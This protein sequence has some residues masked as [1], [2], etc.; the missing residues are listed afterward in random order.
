LQREPRL[1][2]IEIF[3]VIAE[4]RTMTDAAKRLHVT[5]P[6]LSR[7]LRAL[8]ENLNCELFDRIGRQLVLTAAG[9][10]MADE[11]RRLRAEI[12][13]AQTRIRRLLERQYFNLRIGAIDSILAMAMPQ[14]APKLQK[15]F[16]QVDLKIFGDRSGSIINKISAGDL[17]LG[18]VAH[19]KNLPKDIDGIAIARYRLFYYGRRDV[20]PIL[21]QF[22]SLAEVAGLPH[23]RLAKADDAPNAIDPFSAE[24]F[25][26]VTSISSL[27]N[28]VMSGFGI[29]AMAD[30]FVTGDDLE[31]LVRSR[32]SN[33]DENV[34]LQ[35]VWKKGVEDKFFVEI[36]HMIADWVKKAIR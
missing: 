12:K 17:D 18:L 33:E 23:V 8:E 2:D 1:Q 27:K 22:K 34:W 36:R 14:I 21:A 16:P 7:S 15:R 24:T 3:L 26:E 5:Q 11:A 28:L 10:A 25:A 32:F 30:F 31:H 20:F 13:A 9:R 29:G 6:A 35:V 4:S 19:A